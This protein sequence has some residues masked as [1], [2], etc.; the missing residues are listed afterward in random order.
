MARAEHGLAPTAAPMGVGEMQDIRY[1]EYKILLKSERFINPERFKVYW[2]K[3][4]AVA[5]RHK[6]KVHEN[7]D[8]FR[9]HVRE[10]LFFDTRYH[11]LYKNSFIMRSRT[12][13]KDGWPE[14]D[15]EVTFKFR[16]RDRDAAASVDMTPSMSGDIKIKFKEEILPLPDQLGGMRS[17]YS[18]NCVLVSPSLNLSAGIEHIASVVP[19]I[20]S[21]AASAD[22]SKIRLVN[23]FPVKEVQVNVGT[24]DF[25]HGL[26][27]KATIAVWRDRVSETPIVGEFAYQAKFD[28]YD[29]MHT[30]AKARSEEFFKDVQLHTAD[31][32][33][34]GSTKTA[35]VYGRG[36]LA[37][38]GHE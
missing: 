37:A 9:R 30:K 16:H 28:R 33:K 26:E 7:K 36:A 5:E 8:A 18:H 35:L 14:P 12:F 1:R 4:R 19:A 17:L 13:Y 32:V 2:S 34:L 10:V 23:D 15:Q 22:C 27:A 3:V 25:G 6:V 11:D 21:V 31:W 24:L 38:V 20:G 29:L